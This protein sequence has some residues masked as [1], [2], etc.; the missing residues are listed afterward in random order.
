MKNT[1]SLQGDQ[2]QQYP[3]LQNQKAQKLFNK[4]IKVAQ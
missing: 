1:I 3:P 2:P 4:D